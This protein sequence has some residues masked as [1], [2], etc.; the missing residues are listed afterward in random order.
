MIRYAHERNLPVQIFI[1]SG[2]DEVFNEKKKEC[3]PGPFTAV[4][5][6]YPV[7]KP[8]SYATQQE[9]LDSVCETFYKGFQEVFY[10]KT[11]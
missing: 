9:F 2:Y 1:C 10:G 8:S 11:N 6:V 5:K 3:S 4:Y 7:M